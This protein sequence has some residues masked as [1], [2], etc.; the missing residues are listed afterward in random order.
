MERVTI[1]R[2][3]IGPLL[4]QLIHELDIEGS[5]T[6]KAY[7]CR[8]RGHLAGAADDFELATP[9]LELSGS[10]ALGVQFSQTANV[11]VGRIQEKVQA[12][13]EALEGVDPKIH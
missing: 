2:N 8:V 10:I 9:I 7:F 6:Q 1:A 5:S 4:D 12:L 3:Q 11:L 13:L